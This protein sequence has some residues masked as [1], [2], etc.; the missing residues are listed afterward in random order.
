MVEF[1]KTIDGS[2]AEVAAF[3]EGCWIN[4]VRPSSDEIDEIARVTH[5]EEEFV[6]AALD[7][8][9]SSR[10]DIEEDQILMIVD[11]PMVEKNSVED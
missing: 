8:E 1:Y 5:V 4:M 3:T 2:I 7:P 6:R 9:E 11:V 10:V